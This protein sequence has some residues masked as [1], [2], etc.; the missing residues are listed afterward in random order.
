MLTLF[1]LLFINILTCKAYITQQEFCKSNVVVRAV[2]LPK[3]SLIGQLTIPTVPR[4]YRLFEIKILEVYKDDLSTGW[5]NNSVHYSISKDTSSNPDADGC[6]IPDS[7]NPTEALL[8]FDS[9]NKVKRQCKVWTGVTSFE[10]KALRK[11]LYDCT[12]DLDRCYDPITRKNGKPDCDRK[13]MNMIRCTRDANYNCVWKGSK[14]TCL[15][16]NASSKRKDFCKQP[17]NRWN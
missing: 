11:D 5:D 17:F 12:C 4:F 16:C 10:K 2:I 15:S 7:D 8:Y 9:L 13:K 1:C 3:D 6:D 14:K